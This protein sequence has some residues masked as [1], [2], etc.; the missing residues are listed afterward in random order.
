MSAFRSILPDITTRRW[1][2]S[3]INLLLQPRTISLTTSLWRTHTASLPQTRAASLPR[4]SATCW[5]RA[6]AAS[7][8]RSRLTL[9]QH[10]P[11]S[12]RLQIVPSLHENTI[13]APV[14]ADSKAL[15]FRPFEA[16]APASYGI[17]G[18]QGFLELIARGARLPFRKTFKMCYDLDYVNA[19][20]IGIAGRLN[21]LETPRK[22]ASDLYLTNT[23]VGRGQEST[24]TVTMY[25]GNDLRGWVKVQDMS[26]KDTA[27]VE[28]DG[29]QNWP[30]N[31]VRALPSS[32]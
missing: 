2:T 31:D 27:T 24:A 10:A 12:R 20:Y 15:T 3:R 7:L 28:F 21:M 8:P 26:T 11:S 9:P 1:L 23:H 19:A 13:S 32:G 18:S 4:A 14:V 16:E 17:I 29:Y 25:M 5:P 22:I 30:G 6:Y